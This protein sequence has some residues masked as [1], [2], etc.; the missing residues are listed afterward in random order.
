MKKLLAG[1]L[2]VAVLSMVAGAVGAFFLWRAAKPVYDSAVEL[3]DGVSRL[4]TLAVEDRLVNREPYTGPESGELTAEQVERFLRVQARV[5]DT[6]GA[7]A[8]AFKAKYKELATARPDGTEAP[9]SLPQLLAGLKDMSSAYLDARRAQAD[10][11]DAEK[12]SW[13]EFNWV[14]LRVYQ[15]AGA[16]VARY[17]ARE[18]E[19]AIGAMAEGAKLE[20]PEVSLPDVP[21]RNRELVKPHAAQIMEW[22]A[23]ASFGL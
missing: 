16:E 19:R 1:C 14:R 2:V 6:L 8:E 11:L 17:D 13:Q 10:A 20:T 23:M 3:A 18:L 21:A 9:P 5:K 4:P 22:L 15:A 7:R 12:F